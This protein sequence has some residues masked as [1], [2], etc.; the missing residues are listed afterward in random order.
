[1]KK[2]LVTGANSYIGRSFQNLV[3]QFPDKY[4]IDAISVRDDS[5]K[6]RSFIGYEVVFH[7]AA[8]VHVKENDTAKYF[9][10]NRDLTVE[11]AKKAKKEGVNQFI[12]L[13]TMGVYGKNGKIG[14][15]VIITKDTIPRPKTYY[16]MS[17][18]EAEKELMKLTDNKFKI[19]ILRPPIVYGPNC[20]GNYAKL[21]KLAL[22]TPLFPMIHNQRSMI[23]IEKLSADLK[24]YVDI[25]AHG[26]LFPQDDEYINTSLMVQKIAE[27]HGR[28]IILTKSLGWLIKLFGSKVGVFNKVFGNLVYEK[29][30]IK[31]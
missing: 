7:T 26:I 22:K 29:V 11:L 1:M 25:E 15:E 30:D 23:N 17:K 4:T 6:E 16:G 24:K 10:V 28:K 27:Q 2:I 8:I 9:K 20:P 21:E 5:W 12:F 18:L 13:S 19:A 31:N 3:A 14:D